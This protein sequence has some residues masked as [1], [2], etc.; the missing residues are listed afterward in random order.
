MHI[1]YI[2]RS[3]CNWFTCQIQYPLWFIFWSSALKEIRLYLSFSSIITRVWEGRLWEHLKANDR[4]LA[5]ENGLLLEAT[6]PW[7]YNQAL[8]SCKMQQILEQ[9]NPFGTGWWCKALEL[10]ARAIL[11]HWE[12]LFLQHPVRFLGSFSLSCIWTQLLQSCRWHRLRFARNF[13]PIRR[14][15]GLFGWKFSQCLI[16]QSRHYIL[17]HLGT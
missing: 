5:E 12:T 14:N 8:P 7:H 11:Y 15:Y 1:V 2:N 9:R 4:L 10:L 3:H 17:L 13:E 16:S 6:Q